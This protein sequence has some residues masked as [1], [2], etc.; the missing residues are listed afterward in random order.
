VRAEG[1]LVYSTCTF[2]R[3]EN[4]D[5]VAAFIDEYP[6]WTVE[7]ID[8]T[9]GVSPGLDGVGVRVWPHRAAGEGQFVARLRAPASWQP[10]RRDAI[11]RDS[12]GS[13]VRA[14]WSEFARRSLA[15]AA[16]GALVVRGESISLAPRDP[17]V[18]PTILARPGLPLG[19]ARPGRFEPAHALAT[20]LAPRDATH[21]VC[22]DGDDPALTTYL[23]G[24]VVES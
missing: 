8:R 12:A 19:R 13:D 7:P 17:E 1:A 16:A 22:W 9:P 14:A 15:R 3:E 18:H 10:A 2:N 11:R 24:N 20:T 5:R 6:E 4:E 23:A 21:T